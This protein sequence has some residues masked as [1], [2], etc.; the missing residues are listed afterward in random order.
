MLRPIPPRL[1]NDTVVLKIPAEKD[2]WQN[3]IYK[4]VRINR[5]HLQSAHN[6]TKSKD[7]T[8]VLLSAILFIDCKL[9]YPKADIDCLQNYSEKN[10]GNMR[11]VVYNARGQKV[12]DF[13]VMT[14]DGITDYPSTQNHHIEVGLV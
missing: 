4:E 7:N 5:V 2:D 3:P 13:S 9:S 11:A 1:L 14:V 10:G 8:E 12:G 6:I